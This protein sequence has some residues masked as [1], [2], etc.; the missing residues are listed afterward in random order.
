MKVTT[1]K[2][3]DIIKKNQDERETEL[4]QLIEISGSENDVDYYMEVLKECY[5]QYSMP[6]VV[7]IR[8]KH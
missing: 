3:F 7:T 5:P 2:I 8:H 4:K 1:E 6:L